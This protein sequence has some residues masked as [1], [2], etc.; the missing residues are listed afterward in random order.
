MSNTVAHQYNFEIETIITQFI[1][2]IDGAIVIRYDVDEET[3]KRIFVDSIKPPY[4]FGPKHR[5]MYN[6][7]NKAKNYSLPYVAINITGIEGNTDRIAAKHLPI[8][9]FNGKHVLGY[10][11]PTPITISVQV[12]I[13]ADR[14]T[15]LYQI[16]SKLSTQFQPYCAFSWYLP[17]SR[18]EDKTDWEELTGKAEW[19]FNISFDVKDQLQEGDEERYS[20]TMNFKVTGWMFPT[21]KN[22]IGNIIYD[23]GTSNIIESELAS[24]I[25]GLH[26]TIHPLVSDVYKDENLES[27]NNP[28][29]WNNG[30]PRIV[31]LFQLIKIGDKKINFLLDKDRVQ[32]FSLN[33]DKYITFDGYNMK[34]ADILFVPSNPELL[35][36]KLERVTYEYGS[37][38]L[39]PERDGMNKKLPTVEGYKMNIIEQTQN[40]VTVN[41]AD[42]D[43][44]GEFDIVIADNVDYDSTYDKLHKHFE[45][46]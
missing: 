9:R 42:I 6:L 39:F 24:R 38:T 3:K 36:T 35:S 26:N 4:F 15:D 31:N 18:T 33:A 45:S 29:E 1:A 11:R 2:L 34:Y 37:Q 44:K 40:K 8:K 41:F 12:T 7:V 20:G 10:D 17:I 23:I 28:R 16:Y 25:I 14:M 21:N 43:Y 5:V 22:R 32:P 19:D 46:K 27:Y 13:V 30:H